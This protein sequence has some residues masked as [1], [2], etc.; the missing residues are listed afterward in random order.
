MKL[1]ALILCLLTTA[2]SIIEAA[3]ASYDG[4][5]NS[6]DEATATRQLSKLNKQYK[7]YVDAT[8]KTRNSGCTSENV[9]YRQEW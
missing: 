1:S 2:A 6:T 7:E 9:V 8:L 4:S 5:G 3:P